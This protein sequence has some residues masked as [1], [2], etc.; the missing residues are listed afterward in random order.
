MY[1]TLYRIN[2]LISL[3]LHSLPLCSES[4]R[5]VRFKEAYE[6]YRIEQQVVSRLLRSISLPSSILFSHHCAFLKKKCNMKTNKAT[7]KNPALKQAS[8]KAVFHHILFSHFFF[9]SFSCSQ[10]R[11]IRSWHMCLKGVSSQSEFIQ[12]CYQLRLLCFAVYFKMAF[13][14]LASLSVHCCLP[15][16]HLGQDQEERKKNK[17]EWCS[18]QCIWVFSCQGDYGAGQNF[19][20][21]MSKFDWGTRVRSSDVLMCYLERLRSLLLGDMTLGTLQG[22]CLRWSSTE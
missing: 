22:L 21:P 4:C 18:I 7:T 12:Y 3:A 20:H 16:P 19:G 5:D 11:Q 15:K 13:L 17:T 10:I 9:S 2:I 1:C 8:F 6:V 14:Q